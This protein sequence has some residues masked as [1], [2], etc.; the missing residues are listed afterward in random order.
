MKILVVSSKYSAVSAKNLAVALG[1]TLKNPFEDNIDY[2]AFDGVINYGTSKD[3]PHKNIVNTPEAVKRCIDKRTTFAILNKAKLPVV[4]HTLSK[5]DAKAAGWAITVCRTDAKGNNAKDLIYKYPGDVLPD[6]ELYT[7][8]FEHQKELR[9]MVLFGKPSGF[10][11][12][13]RVADGER[14]EFVGHLPIKAVN[15]AAVKAANALGIDYV[16]FDIL[17]NSP[18][19]FAIL[20]ANSGPI[21]TEDIKQ[22]FMAYMK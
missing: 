2:R 14:W 10:Y 8:Y 5:A 13:K 3:I 9:V 1:A 6:A 7:E 20:E 16:G 15:D 4:K 11:E 19:S 21:L 17:Y 18:Q 12:K 22:G